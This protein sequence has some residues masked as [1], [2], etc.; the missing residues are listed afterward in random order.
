MVECR[1]VAGKGK[2][3][4]LTAQ[5]ICRLELMGA[6]VA[7]RLA[8]TLVAEMITKIEK[9]IFWCDSATLDPP[10]EF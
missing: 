1:R 4:P 6:L 8:E 2:V 7:A 9:I 5:S 3:P 10:D